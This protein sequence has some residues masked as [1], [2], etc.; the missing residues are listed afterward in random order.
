MNK[1]LL[2]YYDFTVKANN[3]NSTDKI[4]RLVNINKE[5]AIA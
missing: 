5:H 1:V 2:V 3:S 4:G